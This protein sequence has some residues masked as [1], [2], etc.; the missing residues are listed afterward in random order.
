MG[1]KR[2][3]RGEGADEDIPVLSLVC[4]IEGIKTRDLPVS[5]DAV[6]AAEKGLRFLKKLPPVEAYV[7][8]LEKLRGCYRGFVC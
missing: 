5:P 6:E 8:C 3:S 4:F 7:L 2:R 1:R